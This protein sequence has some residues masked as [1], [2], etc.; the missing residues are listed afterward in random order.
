MGIQAEGGTQI[1]GRLPIVAKGKCY[2]LVFRCHLLFI[3][4]R[5]QYLD[6]KA[7][8]VGMNDELEKLLKEPVVP[9]L[10]CYPRM[11]LKG[12]K[13][14]YEYLQPGLSVSQTR[15]EPNAS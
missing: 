1:W 15:F 14:I 3:S 7:S 5:C 9:S 13:K 2:M 10:R 8:N 6:Y 4:R 11:C 12:L